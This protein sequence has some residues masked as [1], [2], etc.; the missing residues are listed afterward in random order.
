[1][2]ISPQAIDN[3]NFSIGDLAKASGCKVQTVRYYEQIGLL[4]APPRSLGNQRVYGDAHFRRLAFIRRSRELGFTIDMVRELLGMAD[5][6]DRSC[7]MVDNIASR[8]LWHVQEKI[9]ALKSLQRE[10]KRLLRHD[11]GK[12]AEC[13]IIE[14]LSKSTTDGARASKRGADGLTPAR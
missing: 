6:P 4:P 9:R 5:T 12:V 14:A 1:M 2:M 11:G 13:Q 3:T 8:H 10:L 7:E